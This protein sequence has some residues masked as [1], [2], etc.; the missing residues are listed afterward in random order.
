MEERGM[1]L[2]EREY[3]LDVTYLA[4]ISV[5]VTYLTVFYGPL[6]AVFCC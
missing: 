6:S 4:Y 2:G 1:G 5:L 3:L